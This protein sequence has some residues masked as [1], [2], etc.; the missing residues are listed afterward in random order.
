MVLAL[1]NS[2]EV[3][4]LAL[5]HVGQ[6]LCQRCFHPPERSSVV[7]P[8]AAF[9]LLAE[10]GAEVAGLEGIAIGLG[11][12]S[13]TGLRI[14]LSTAKTLAYAASIPLAGVS[15]L[16]ALA[17]E[18]PPGSPLW[19]TGVFRR[20]EIFA[21]LFVRTQEGGVE[22]LEEERTFEIAPFAKRLKAMPQTPA[23]GFGIH[24]FR[25]AFLA[26]GV[27]A[28]QLLG[29]PIWPSAVCIA[30]LARFS[31]FDKEALFALAPSYL[32]GSGA[33]ENPLFAQ[34]AVVPAGDT[35]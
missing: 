2:T 25:E 32:R 9:A 10:G 24:R 3:L 34:S 4:S 31:P 19:A 30:Q 29:H 14:G 28:Q 15:S 1:D 6:V 23:L 22:V 5:L 11:P 35:P 18:G 7:L 16:K 27:A 8:E 12:G 17:L 33:E 20:G 21:G 13:F 26:E